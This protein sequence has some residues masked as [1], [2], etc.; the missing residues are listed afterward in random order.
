[1][2]V[3][4]AT[5][6]AVHEHVNKGTE[7]QERVGDHAQQVRPVLFP[8]KEDGNGE[9]QAQAEPRRYLK[10]ATL[11]VQTGSHTR[12]IPQGQGQRAPGKG[13]RKPR[14]FRTRQREG[15]TSV[16]DFSARCEK[17]RGTVA[18]YDKCA[19]RGVSETKY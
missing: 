19:R 6:T 13:P 10:R 17:V 14:Q 15:T 11:S 7:E 9:E 16:R 5:M 18:I 1:M 3:P 8:E 4:V 2:T 12:A